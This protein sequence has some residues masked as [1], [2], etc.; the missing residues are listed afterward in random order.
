MRV[1]ASAA[2]GVV[3]AYVVYNAVMLNGS[4]AFGAAVAEALT[5]GTA[6]VLYTLK[7][8]KVKTHDRN[9]HITAHEGN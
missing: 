4:Y 5:S 1:C 9:K 6:I 2:V 3:I 8:G 7:K